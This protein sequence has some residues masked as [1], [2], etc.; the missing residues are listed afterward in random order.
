MFQDISVKKWLSKGCPKDKLVL[1][2][3]SSGRTYT[4]ESNAQNGLGAKVKGPGAAGKYTKLDG[5]YSN[6]I[7][8][9]I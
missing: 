1:G 6:N 7:F 4:L 8:Y 3:L 9:M 5:S 2:V